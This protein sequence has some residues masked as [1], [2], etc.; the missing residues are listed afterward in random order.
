MFWFL[1][2]IFPLLGKQLDVEVNSSSAILMNAETGAILFE[3]QP[4]MRSNPASTTKIATT[5][6]ILQ[7]GLD[8]SAPM[9]VSADCL[10]M[11]EIGGDHPYWLESDGTMMYLKKGE[12]LPLD[13]LLHGMMLVSGNDAANTVA[14]GTSG[15]IAKFV[16]ELNF[17]VEKLGC[18]NTQFQN[19]HGLTHPAHFSTAYDLALL[20]QKALQF[21]KFREL[22]STLSYTV[23]KTNKQRSR[24]LLLTN[25]FLKPKNRNYYS[26][27]IGGKSGTT[28]AAG[29]PFVQAAS[30]NG[31]TLIAVILGTPKQTDRYRDTRRL[32]EA[33][34]AETKTKRRLLGPETTFTKSLPTAT[35]PLKASLSKALTIEFFPAEEP[36][37]KAA[38]HWNVE[39]FPI[40]KGQKVGEVHI[41]DAKDTFLQKADLIALEGIS[42]NFFLKYKHKLLNLFE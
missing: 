3:K 8:L 38:L 21:P 17:F 6:F 12:V 25:Q 30:H 20:M 33:A 39:R 27:A 29:F 24:E 14:E 22:I 32:F 2:L 16:E 19:P 15:S 13:A 10:K 31:R 26:K 28:A 41:L 35:R 4:H 9:T 23:P 18:V 42:E 36:E 5:L 7:K 1:C 11:K 40:R 37:C 34:F